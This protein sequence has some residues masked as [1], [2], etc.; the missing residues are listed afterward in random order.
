M[1]SSSNA[2][3]L[4]HKFCL[5]FPRFGPRDFGQFAGR[6]EFPFD[7]V[8]TNPLKIGK[9]P[10]KKEAPFGLREVAT[11]FSREKPWRKFKMAFDLSSIT[12]GE[13]S[14]THTLAL[15]P[16]ALSIVLRVKRKAYVKTVLPINPV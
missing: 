2:M 6:G 8:K 13:A 7:K 16:K 10:K 3:T 5:G 11:C 9:L 4:S 1:G 15:E 12:S 14:L